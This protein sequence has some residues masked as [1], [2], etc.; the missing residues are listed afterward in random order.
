[1]SYESGSGSESKLRRQRRYF[2]LPNEDYPEASAIAYLLKTGH[3]TFS[4]P[5]TR[6]NIH[7]KNLRVYEITDSAGTFWFWNASQNTENDNLKVMVPYTKEENAKLNEL[8]KERKSRACIAKHKCIDFWKM[9]E[10]ERRVERYEQ[11]GITRVASYW[12]SKAR[13]FW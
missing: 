11:T 2:W 8:F 7:E 1:M 10:G 12:S 6:D 13:R 4:C 9:K 5:I 3:N